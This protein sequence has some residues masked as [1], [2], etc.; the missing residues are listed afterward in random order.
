MVSIEDVISVNNP[1]LPSFNTK[2]KCRLEN[3]HSIVDYYSNGKI[4][5]KNVKHLYVIGNRGAWDT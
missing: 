3:R 2:S 5:V 4:A 1:D